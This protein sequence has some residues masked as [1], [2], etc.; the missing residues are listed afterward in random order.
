MHQCKLAL[1]NSNN[2]ICK[3]SSVHKTRR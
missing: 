2:L 3:T 1:S